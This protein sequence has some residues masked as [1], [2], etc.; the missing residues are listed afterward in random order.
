MNTT[1]INLNVLA[2]IV[3]DHPELNGRVSF[4]TRFDAV[5]PFHVGFV[6]HVRIRS[7]TDYTAIFGE[8]RERSLLN[9]LEHYRGH[10]SEEGGP[11]FTLEGLGFIVGDGDD[12]LAVVEVSSYEVM[13]WVRTFGPIGD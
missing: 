9:L 2:V 6:T 1:E 8:R 11:D 12:N 5:S 3:R 10:E 13:I 4:E 7:H